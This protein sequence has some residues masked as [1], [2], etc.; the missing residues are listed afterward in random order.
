MRSCFAFLLAVAAI[1]PAA[2]HAA[3]RIELLTPRYISVAGGES[4]LVSVQVFDSAGK[5][6][7]GETVRFANDACGRFHNGQFSASIVANA[8]GVVTVQFTASNPPGITCWI[9]ASAGAAYLVVDVLT[10]SVNG[11]R[12]VTNTYPDAPK[13]GERFNLTAQPTYGIYGLRD[14]EVTARVING[15]GT[16]TVS[17]S[18]MN[19]GSN[20]YAEFEVVPAGNGEFMV[21]TAYRTQ[22][23]FV[24][25]GGPPRTWQDMWW[26]GA[27]ENG[28]GMSIVQHRDVMFAVIYAYDEAGKPTWFVIPGGL[29]N[30]A[31]TEFTGQA[32]VPTGSPYYSYE[33]SR[34]LVGPSVGPVKL[35]FSGPDNATLEYTLNG[36]SGRKELKRHE[37]GPPALTEPAGVG[38][39]WWGGS[40]QNGW[41]IAVLQQYRTLFTVW[42]TYGADGAPTWYVMPGGAWTD[43]DTYEGRIFRTVSSAWLGV[44]YDASKFKSADVGSFKLHLNGDSARFEYTLEGR[45]GSI[46]LMR[47]SF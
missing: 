5:A 10:Y 23:G 20:G 35:S 43:A 15:T 7:A 37:F 21:E 45:S 34:F 16:A 4:Q 38:D 13:V 29:W 26:V 44:G 2:S 27:A 41:G 8:S 17:R 6:A 42:F 36:K 46:P 33:P 22:K 30:A 28:W 24:V 3:A 9:T 47:Y 14:V 31:R 25:A 32:F 18:S 11:V 12:M 19:T 40:A 39:M 1:V